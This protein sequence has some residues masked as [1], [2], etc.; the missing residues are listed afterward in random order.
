MRNCRVKQKSLHN[1]QQYTSAKEGLAFAETA[2]KSTMCTYTS[3]QTKL[4]ESFR[5]N[6]L[7]KDQYD[8][9]IEKLTRQYEIDRAPW[10]LYV[11]KLTELVEQY[12]PQNESK[13][14]K[15]KSI[16]QLPTK[17]KTTTNTHIVFSSESSDSDTPP[18][19]PSTTTKAIIKYDSSTNTDP[20]ELSLRSPFPPTPNII[21][22][23][24]QTAQ[25]VHRIPLQHINEIAAKQ[26]VLLHD[27]GQLVRWNDVLWRILTYFQVQDLGQLGLQR[28]D[29]IACIDNL[30]RTQ[31]KINTYLD[32]YTYW[33]T[34]GTIHELELD[35][36]RLFS[37]V[38]FDE[39][40][41]G[42][43][44]KQPKIEELFRLKCLRNER[45]KKEL[46]SS[47]IL[48]YLDQYMTKAYAWKNDKEIHLDSFLKFVAEKVQAKNIYQLGIRIK[49]VYLARNV[50]VLL[51]FCSQSSLL[52]FANPSVSKLCKPIRE[53]PWKSLER[54]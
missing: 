50:R 53:R 20:V 21:P 16:E 17:K 49:S 28:A 26:I 35:L 39:L 27:E 37:K 6:V 19:V 11:K 47:D 18:P 22:F 43:V 10:D 4:E 52:L 40:L 48:K 33:Q 5:Q 23:T 14:K 42:P 36:A 32:A 38:S 54:N 9:Q 8:Q 44:E 34:L 1:N 51:V 24:A 31:N 7:S 15:S 12:S 2:I 30:I 13:R 3:Q 29:Q 45:I 46:K 25:I 41:L